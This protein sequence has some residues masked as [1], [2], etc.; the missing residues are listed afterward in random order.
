MWISLKD[1][2]PEF[3]ENVIVT[4]GEEV[5]VLFLDTIR[6]YK[7]YTRYDFSDINGWTILSPT[8]WMPLPEL[9]IN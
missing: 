6:Q 2:V 3:G 4:D 7:D 9:P 1:K 8:H 5:L